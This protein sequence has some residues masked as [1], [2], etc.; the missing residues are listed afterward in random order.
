MLSQTGQKILG[1]V[2]NIT[3]SNPSIYLGNSQ[4]FTAT[5]LYSDGSS[6]DITGAVTW[7]SPVL[8]VATMGTTT[9]VAYVV[10]PGSTTIVARL[11]TAQ[12]SG[13]GTTQLVSPTLVSDG[14]NNSFAGAVSLGTLNCGTSSVRNGTT[15]PLE[16]RIGSYSLGWLTHART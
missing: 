14:I 6:Q 2:I 9:G 8:P 15:F 7:S 16:L 13:T 4:Q 1:G 11:S 12:E 5:G 3:P 10:A